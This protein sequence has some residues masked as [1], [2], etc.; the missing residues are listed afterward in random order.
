MTKT[1]CKSYNSFSIFTVNFECSF[2]STVPKILKLCNKTI[3]FRVCHFK[4][5]NVSYLKLE[6][7]LRRIKIKMLVCT[8]YT[9]LLLA[10]LIDPDSS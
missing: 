4:N 1:S 8:R 9:L 7:L 6:I 3:N 10:F 2:L 5:L